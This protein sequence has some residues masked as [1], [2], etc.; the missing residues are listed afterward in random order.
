MWSLQ[1]NSYIDKVTTIRQTKS[2]YNKY[3]VKTTLMETTTH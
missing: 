1:D 3:P 2:M